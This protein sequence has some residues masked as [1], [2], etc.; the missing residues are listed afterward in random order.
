MI[1]R[2][3]CVRYLLYTKGHSG[4][5]T[6][7][8]AGSSFQAFGIRIAIN[9]GGA[10]R[11]NQMLTV[12]RLDSTGLAIRALPFERIT[13][14]VIFVVF[15]SRLVGACCSHALQSRRACTCISAMLPLPASLVHRIVWS[16]PY[17]GP[18]SPRRLVAHR[19]S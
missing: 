2:T 16:Q 1:S 18:S 4:S 10:K 8:H 13:R 14:P 12:A 7:A 17:T 6:I 11:V 3:F 15:S 5:R 9:A 19:R